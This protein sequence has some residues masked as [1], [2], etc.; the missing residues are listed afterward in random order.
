MKITSTDLRMGSTHLATQQHEIRESLRMW[1]GRQRPDF[2]GDRSGER[3]PAGDRV[4]ISDAGKAA[5]NCKAGDA[6]KTDDAANNDPKLGLI[7]TLLEFLTGKKIKLFD[8]SDLVRADGGGAETAETADSGQQ[9]TAAPPS[10]E[11]PPAGY[12]VEYDYHESYSETEKTT[13]SAS[14]TVKTADGRE[15]QF[16]LDLTMERSFQVESQTSLRL[17]DAAR[18][19]D[20]LVINFGGTAAQLS[21]TRFQFDIDADGQAEQ[22]HTLGAGSGFLA[23]DRNQDGKINDGHELFGA[24]TGDGFGELAALDDDHN[25]WIDEN[26][27]AYKDLRVWSKTAANEDSLQTLKEAKVGAISLAHVATPFDLKD[28]ANRTLGQVLSSGIFLGE[29]GGAGSVQQIDLT[30]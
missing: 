10:G 16:Q 5:R 27:A 25:G 4:Q 9:A 21:D 15:I 11:A 13:F 8:A 6:G 18:R 12:G 20:P 19:K 24:A 14:G 2:E 3:P 17:G 26:D 30:V 22:I 7:K 23:L 28:S 1:A 29:D